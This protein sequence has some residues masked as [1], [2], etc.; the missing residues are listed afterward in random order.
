MV[1]VVFVFVVGVDGP[2]ATIY[3]WRDGPHDTRRVIPSLMFLF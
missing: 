1:V 3:T 2:T